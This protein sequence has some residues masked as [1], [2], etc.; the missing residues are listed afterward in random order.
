MELTRFTEHKTGRV[1]PIRV[2]DRQDDWAFVP[3][4]L[5]PS[6]TQHPRLWPLI[7]QAHSQIARLDGIG[8]NLVDARLLLRP[9]QRLEALSS[10]S[11]EGTFVTPTEL[12]LFEAQKS[13]AAP[14]GQRRTEDW[15][16]VLNYDRAIE[17]GCRL[18]EQG[19]ELNAA[20]FCELHAMLLAG[21]RGRDKRPGAFRNTQVYVGVDRRYIPPPAD[22]V[23]AC[24]ADL[25]AYLGAGDALDPLVRAYVAHY[26]FEAIHPFHDGNGRLGRLLLSLM[27]HKWMRLS[28]PFLYMSEFFDKNRKDYIEKLYRV[29]THGEWDEWIEFCLLGTIEQADSSIRRC[30]ELQAL[31]A[32]YQ[33]DA[34]LTGRRM[35]TLIDRLFS[36]PIVTIAE[37]AEEFDVTYHTA[38]SDVERLV[39]AGILVQITNQRPKAFVAR[40][41][42]DIA[43]VA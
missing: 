4:P 36:A 39:R 17:H 26:Q 41:I 11:L 22:A 25:E 33:Q 21:G 37:I 42:F 19:R 14:A 23:A 34:G 15:R 40:E 43:Y 29:S 13:D 5:P 9:L 3:N 8:Q 27:I 20:L 24:V 7:V 2:G 31:K 18:I 16:E 32:R 30:Q 6:W 28:Q 1:L 38:Q 10:N 12:L 35:H